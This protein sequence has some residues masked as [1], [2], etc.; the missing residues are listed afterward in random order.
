[1]NKEA[2]TPELA[3]GAV[4]IAEFRRQLHELADWVAD[5][6]EHIG[7]IRVGPNQ[8]PGTVQAALPA[9]PPETGESFNK[10]FDDVKKRFVRNLLQ[11]SHPDSPPYLG[12][13][14]PPPG[15]EGELFSATFNVNAMTW[16]TSP[17]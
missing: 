9:E 4:P 15:I 13:P 17:A 14:T 11:W 3:L 7:E 6:R 1:M 16:R 8:E 12:R 5:Y 10:I 2:K